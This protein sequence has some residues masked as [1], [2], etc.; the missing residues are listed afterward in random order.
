MYMYVYIYKYD[1]Y[2]YK[3]FID[4]EIEVNATCPKL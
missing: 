1:K 3:Y 2:S 4:E